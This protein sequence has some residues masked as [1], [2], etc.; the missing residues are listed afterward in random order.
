[1]QAV[2]IDLC[3]AWSAKLWAIL[4]KG[5]HMWKNQYVK[6][7]NFGYNLKI[8]AI[9]FNPPISR[10]KKI[11]PVRLYQ[12]NMCFLNMIARRIYLETL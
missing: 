2:S 12:S 8:T 10:K 6:Q 4:H 5:R 1:M 3:H 9:Y 7:I 11:G